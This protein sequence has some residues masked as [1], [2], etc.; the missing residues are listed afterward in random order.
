MLDAKHGISISLKKHT[1]LFLTVNINSDIHILVT[2]VPTS[3][4]YQHQIYY[5]YF[6]VQNNAVYSILIFIQEE[7]YNLKL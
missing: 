4:L 2:M 1:D 6:I 3:N 5:L 7:S